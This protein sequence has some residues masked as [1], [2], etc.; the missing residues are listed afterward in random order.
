MVYNVYTAK[1]AAVV[2]T[3]SDAAKTVAADATKTAADAARTAACV[4]M[5]EAVAKATAV[6]HADRVMQMRWGSMVWQL[7]EMT[8]YM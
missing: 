5:K 7:E 8:M 3:A 6:T 4:A 1:I 2:K